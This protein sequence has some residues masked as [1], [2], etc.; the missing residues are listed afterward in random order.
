MVMCVDMYF[1]SLYTLY[2]VFFLMIRRPP[3]STRTDTLFPYTTLFRSHDVYGLVHHI[4]RVVDERH[5]VVQQQTGPQ[6]GGDRDVAA[7]VGQAALVVDL[8]L[9]DDFAH[10]A[11]APGQP[12]RL[13][14]RLRLRHAAGQQHPALL[15]GEGDARIQVGVLGEEQAVQLGLDTGVVRSDTRRVGKGCGS[16]VRS[17]RSP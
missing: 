1:T 10:V 9:V 6:L 4:D 7:L 13:D 8:D 11:H 5:L 14:P 17:R 15:H 2:F 12:G 3:R 16:R